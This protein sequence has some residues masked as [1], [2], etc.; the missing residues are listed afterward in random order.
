MRR[1]CLLLAVIVLASP[2]LTS[3]QGRQAQPPAA[4]AAQAPAA[5]APAAPAR[6]GRG[7]PAAGGA[8]TQAGGRGSG[9]PLQI[10][11]D[12]T[13][14]IPMFDGVSLKGWDGPMPLWHVED[15]AIVVRRTGD[16]AIGSVYLIWQGGQPK[17]FEMKFDVKLEGDGANSGLQFRAALLGEVPDRP[18]VAGYPLTKWETH[19]YQADMTNMGGA[20]NLIECCRG[21][22]RGL[23]PRP[24]ANASR[25]QVTRSA[26]TEGGPKN[27][28]ATV[29]DSTTLHGYWKSSDW[30][31]IDVIARGRT[32][33]Y[34][35]NGHLM[36]VMMD[37]SPTLYQ[38]HG[39]LAIQLEGAPPNAAYFKNL[40]I[41]LLPG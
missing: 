28:I 37:D 12:L 24:D 23:P 5:P 13:G 14:W 31:T 17:D 11:T 3:A 7:T 40:W 32:F 6:G 21:P 34:I 9:A 8:A 1:P 4:P 19:G 16:P 27:L 10:S 18:P 15:G 39:Y 33:L 20:G 22:N 36:S 2:M 25:G 30:N 29:E 35:C 41:K 38:D 26:T